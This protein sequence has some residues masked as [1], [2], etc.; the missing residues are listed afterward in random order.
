MRGVAKNSSF[1]HFMVVFMSYCRQFWGSGAIYKACETRTCLT[2]IIKNSSFYGRFVSYCT[3]F[4]G[5]WMISKA[6]TPATRFEGWQKTLCFS[7]FMAV[8]WA[9][10]HFVW[11]PWRFPRPVTLGTWF[12]RCC[13][14]LVVFTFYGRF[15]E[16]L[17]TVLGSWA[18]YKARDTQ[19]MV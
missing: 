15:H 4:W 19:Y 16:L 3:L 9:I 1:S 17:P 8:S 6:L 13:Q 10:A 7:H 18:I 2:G 11:V 5:P 14:K 12:E